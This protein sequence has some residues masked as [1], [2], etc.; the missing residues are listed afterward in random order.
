MKA[1]RLAPAISILFLCFSFAA[2]GSVGDGD[3]DVEISTDTVEDSGST[4]DEGA[5]PT[6]EGPATDEGQ[7]SACT[8]G[9][10]EFSACDESTGECLF[11][12]S[13][14]MDCA[15]G[16]ECLSGTCEGSCGCDGN[17]GDYC[18]FGDTYCDDTGFCVEQQVGYSDCESG[19]ECLSGGCTNDLCHCSAGECSEAQYCAEDGLCTDRKLGGLGCTKASEC[20]SHVCDNGICAC[21]SEVGC[22]LQQVCEAGKCKFEGS[23]I[24]LCS[25]CSAD[26]YCC[27]LSLSDFCEPLGMVICNDRR[28]V[29]EACPNNSI[30]DSGFCIKTGNGEVIE[31][32]LLNLSVEMGKCGCLINA[33][34]ASGNC[35]TNTNEC[36]GGAPLEICEA[37]N[38]ET[39]VCVSGA[40]CLT[41][42]VTS[43]CVDYNTLNYGDTC[44]KTAQC[45]GSMMCADNGNGKKCYQ[46]YGQACGPSNNCALGAATGIPAEDVATFC[47]PGLQV[48]NPSA[49]VPGVGLCGPFD[50]VPTGSIEISYEDDEV[51]LPGPPIA[52]PAIRAALGNIWEEG[53]VF[54]PSVPFEDLL[55]GTPLPPALFWLPAVL[56]ELATAHACMAPGTIPQGKHCLGT[57]HCQEGLTCKGLP[58]WAICLP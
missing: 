44:C 37:C 40:S 52:H 41:T 58:F 11:L 53:E 28:A 56:Q 9:C 33:D 38:P 16:A 47:I 22:P 1:I 6:D 19:A 34:C 12:L 3:K 50:C 45:K 42:G 4:E 24:S 48:C 2:C 57:N 29:D 5:P 13:G 25:I 31:T 18:H 54:D 51:N 35:N 30:C 15:D 27:E 20:A 55:A 32:D 10:D 43:A 23:V 21:N 49:C 46:G 8:D 39:D 17:N 7:T 26:Q 36:V 14:G